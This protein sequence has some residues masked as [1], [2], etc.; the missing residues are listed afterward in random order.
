MKTKHEMMSHSLEEVRAAYIAYLNTQG[1]TKNTI[2]TSKSDAFYLW[3]K[4][5]KD[6]F[7]SV[8]YSPDFEG[9]GKDILLK[10]LKQ[11]SKGDA[12]TNVNSYMAHLRRFRK[13]LASESAIDIA[14]VTSKSEA[15]AR[16]KPHKMKQHLPDP[17][18]EQV[19]QYLERW[20]SLEEYRLQEDA[21]DKLFFELCP[22]NKVISDVLLKVSALNDFYS[23]HIFKVFPMAKHIVALDIDERLKAGDVSLVGDIQKGSSTNRNYYSFATKYCSH[24]QPLDYPMYDSYVQTVMRYYARRDEF[25]IFS[26]S[27]LKNYERFKIILLAFRS[28]YGLEAYNLKE[29][30]KYIWLLGKDFF[31]KTYY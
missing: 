14:I 4:R 2:N 19:E 11:Y 1:L 9:L 29:I 23:T 25:F 10:T 15:M 17:C 8:I 24:H 31:Q 21:L 16:H 13:F 26:D 18:V 28:F 22:E 7:W 30:D 27:D 5:G 20:D 12:D 3:K 6:V